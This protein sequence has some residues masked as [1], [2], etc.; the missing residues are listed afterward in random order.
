MSFV[1]G[2]LV[3]IEGVYE[4]VQK[5]CQQYSYERIQQNFIEVIGVEVL[6]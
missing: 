2:I 3:P 1:A 5:D 4:A 6:Y